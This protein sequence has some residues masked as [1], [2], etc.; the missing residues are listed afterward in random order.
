[1][2]DHL[3][4]SAPNQAAADALREN[5]TD[6]NVDLWPKDSGR[7]AVEVSVTPQDKGL[8]Y[9]AKRAYL[10]LKYPP[11]KAKDA[12]IMLGA[13]FV[14]KL[15]ADPKLEAGT[16][17]HIDKEG[18]ELIRTVNGVVK[19]EKVSFAETNESVET[20]PRAFGVRLGMDLVSSPDGDLDK[21]VARGLA[22][23][24]SRDTSARDFLMH[25]Y[26]Q[27]GHYGINDASVAG[28]LLLN[29]FQAMSTSALKLSDGD[30][31]LVGPDKAV[32]QT[33][34]KEMTVSLADEALL[35]RQHDA[36]SSAVI[37]VS[38]EQEKLL[39][40]QIQTPDLAAFG[41]SLGNQLV[42]AVPN[43][44]VEGGKQAWGRYGES[45]KVFANNEHY[46]V[47]RNAKNEYNVFDHHG[48]EG[49]L[50]SKTGWTKNFEDVKTALV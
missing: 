16:V 25:F 23:K 31:L 21:K 17:L 36:A 11:D 33:S 3:P 39:S 32:L 5:A 10:D 30:L 2:S 38:H 34:G 13:L 48:P 9:L 27:V 35:S 46:T 37:A 40:S 18:A 29:R 20:A 6:K 19:N 14:E 41:E 22:F 15:G 44:I 7:T 47:V 43:V 26:M 8:T 4:D 50:Q 49:S 42:A 45:W 28:G 12:C 1:M 24:S